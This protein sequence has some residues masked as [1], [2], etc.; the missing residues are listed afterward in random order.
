[1]NASNVKNEIKKKMRPS[2]VYEGRGEWLF[3]GIIIFIMIVLSITFLYPYWHVLVTSLTSPDAAEGSGFKLWPKVFSF[4]SYTQMF[5]TK[6]LWT[7]YKNTLIVV[8]M[9]WAVSI[10]LNILGAYALS[11]KTLPPVPAAG[12]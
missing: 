6:T 5:H 3:Q 11:K 1:M 4:D 12:S 9:G 8:V 7:G 10:S 2:H